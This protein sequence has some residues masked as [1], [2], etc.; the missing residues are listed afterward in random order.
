[1]ASRLRGD[2][3][4]AALE[5]AAAK[6]QAAAG[7]KPDRREPFEKHFFLLLYKAQMEPYEQR[8]KTLNQASQILNRG[9]ATCREAHQKKLNTAY[10]Q[11]AKVS[12][13]AH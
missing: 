13:T 9:P 4:I 10:Q 1:M 12:A 6:Y 7:M 11:L 5:E 3:R 2:E 8:I